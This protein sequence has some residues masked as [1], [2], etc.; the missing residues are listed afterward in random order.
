VHSLL[1]TSFEALANLIRSGIKRRP[2]FEIGFI[3]K[4]LKFDFHRVSVEQSPA[5]MQLTEAG[6]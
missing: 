1:G 5:L 2:L 3:N 4:N 6:L